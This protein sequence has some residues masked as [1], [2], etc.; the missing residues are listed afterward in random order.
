[1]AVVALTALVMLGV[2]TV[3]RLPDAL[4]ELGWF[5]I[6]D[7]SVTGHRYLSPEDVRIAA[8]L[9]AGAGIWD[10]LDQ[11]LENLESHVAIERARLARRLPG[12]LVIDIVERQPVALLPDPA[13]IPIDRE[14]VRL[15]IDP[16]LH[17][18][19][20]PLVHARR[21]P[22]GSGPP[23][24]AVQLRTLARE[25]ARLAEVNPDVLATVSDV[26]MDLWGD[27]R[28]RLESGVVF[29]YRVPVTSR[30]LEEGL[31]VLVDALER[32]PERRPAEVD[33]RFA[34]QVVVR[35]QPSVG[36]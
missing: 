4:S 28:M 24:T 20:L 5:E 3:P 35:L 32:N 30:R 26:G 34:D 6:V 15:P 17:R 33:L 12:R 8:A 25:L 18:L 1:M 9:P 16:V 19:D 10:D 22:E 11:V 29:R 14:G 2:L 31:A 21:D 7:V 13:L 36:D 27:V 23:L